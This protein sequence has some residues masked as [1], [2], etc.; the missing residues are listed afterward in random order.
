MNDINAIKVVIE[1]LCNANIKQVKFALDT[2][3]NETT[4]TFKIDS[5]T[6]PDGIK[7]RVDLVDNQATLYHIEVLGH[8]SRVDV[9]PP[10]IVNQGN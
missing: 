10:Q 7:I 3:H 5:D 2:K 6:F 8:A 4:K 1:A 9:I